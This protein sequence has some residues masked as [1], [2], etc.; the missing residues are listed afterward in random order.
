MTGAASDTA[1]DTIEW[2]YTAKDIANNHT[3]DGIVNG[4]DSA[5]YTVENI[6]LCWHLRYVAE[7]ITTDAGRFGHVGLCQLRTKTI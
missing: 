5:R 7:S 3:T 4:G 6:S 1:E 2:G